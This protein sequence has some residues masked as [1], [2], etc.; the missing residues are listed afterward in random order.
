MTR[1]KRI[2]GGGKPRSKVEGS[3]EVGKRGKKA[4]GRGGGEVLGVMEREGWGEDERQDRRWRGS[5]GGRGRVD[6]EGS[7]WFG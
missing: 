3:V 2:G 7:W 1:D 5:G 4:P 6:A